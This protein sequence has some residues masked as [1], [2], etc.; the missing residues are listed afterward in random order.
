MK[1]SWWSQPADQ[2]KWGWPV[3]DILPLTKQ[4]RR[5]KYSVTRTFNPGNAGNVGNRVSASTDP[6]W[7]GAVSL[8]KTAAN[9]NTHDPATVPPS[10]RRCLTGHQLMP[11]GLSATAPHN[12]YL[13]PSPAFHRLLP[14]NEFAIRSSS[15]ITCQ[16]SHTLIK[17]TAFPG[18]SS[19]PR[20]TTFNNCI[21]ARHQLSVATLLN[22]SKQPIS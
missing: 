22:P 6:Y 11:C 12:H 16:Q 13:F 21:S 18:T 4:A 5:S 7:G 17:A 20:I 9:S 19:R 10:T 1:V 14:F 8:R 3:C 2:Q 15:S